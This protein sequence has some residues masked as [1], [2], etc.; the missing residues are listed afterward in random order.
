[1]RNIRMPVTLTLSLS[2]CLLGDF[3]VTMHC[4]RCNVGRH[5]HLDQLVK[6]AG[7]AADKPIIELFDAGKL[8]CS[9][10]TKP[11]GGLTVERTGPTPLAN[12]VIVRFWRTGSA[13]DPAV[14]AYWEGFRKAKAAG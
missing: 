11:W 9:R 6:V 3:R 1:M 12:G 10:C 2:D 7:P 8:V 4:D 14:R 13:S 5:A